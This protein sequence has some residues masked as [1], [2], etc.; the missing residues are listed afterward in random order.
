MAD[1]RDVNLPGEGGGCRGRRH[2][3]H[4]DCQEWKKRKGTANYRSAHHY[5]LRSQIGSEVRPTLAYP[6]PICAAG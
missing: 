3:E 2:Q 6:P 5:D 1:N 4:Q